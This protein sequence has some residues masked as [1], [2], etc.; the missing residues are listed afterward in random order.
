MAQPTAKT[1]PGRYATAPIIF[2]FT[3]GTVSETLMDWMPGDVLIAFNAHV[4]TAKTVT[5]VSK[6]K[7]R[8]ADLTVGPQ[9]IAAGAYYVFPR[10][11]EQD[12]DVLS[13]TCES[14]D[15]KLARLST[16]AQPA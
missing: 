5:V 1:I 11:G 7:S 14:T 6:P 15:I 12:A 10:F 16:R 13:V 9:S 2:A 8:R 4:D 3:A